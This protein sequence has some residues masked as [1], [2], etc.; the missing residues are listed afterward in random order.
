MHEQEVPRSGNTIVKTVS[1][2]PEL[3][4]RAAAYSQLNYTSFSQ[5]VRS[6][7]LEYLRNHKV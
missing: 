2:P 6:A 4:K 1:L 5:L 7:L 3:C